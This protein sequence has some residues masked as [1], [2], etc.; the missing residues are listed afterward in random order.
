MIILVEGQGHVP[1]HQPRCGPIY[2]EAIYTTAIPLPV[3]G[4]PVVQVD[5]QLMVVSG[6]A[7]PV[8][9]MH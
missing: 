9:R 2:D 4:A 3:P 7:R 8:T 1:I 6:F 5:S